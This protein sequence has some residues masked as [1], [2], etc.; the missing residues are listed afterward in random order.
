MQ[1]K[2]T[3]VRKSQQINDWNINKVGGWSLLLDT[4]DNF[5]IQDTF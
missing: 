1:V 4:K 5:N 2:I 3:I